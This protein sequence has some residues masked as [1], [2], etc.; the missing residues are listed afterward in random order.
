MARTCTA[1]AA[2]EAAVFGYVRESISVQA[3]VMATTVGAALSRTLHQGCS[4]QNLIW[5]SHSC[6]FFRPLEVPRP[7]SQQLT[8]ARVSGVVQLSPVST[9]VVTNIV[10]S[11]RLVP[12][13]TL[14]AKA[15]HTPR[16]QRIDF[17]LRAPFC[18][19]A[20]RSFRFK[21]SVRPALSW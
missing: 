2:S 8:L 3:T 9:T 10:F 12:Q 17:D 16:R 5:Q 19:S 18:C 13:V 6:K 14:Q 4:S 1:G 15:P 21:N 11:N 7:P 20:P